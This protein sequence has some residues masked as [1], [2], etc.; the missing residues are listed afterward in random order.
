MVGTTGFSKLATLK[1]T[2]MTEASSFHASVVFPQDCEEARGLTRWA[3]GTQT[4]LFNLVVWR[5]I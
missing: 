4:G 1:S 5:L 3:I 2:F